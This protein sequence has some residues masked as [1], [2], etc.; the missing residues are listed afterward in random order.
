MM[1]RGSW[2]LLLATAGLSV[3]AAPAWAAPQFDFHFGL[4]STAPGTPSGLSLRLAARGEGKPP[5]LRSA[6]Y[7]A[8]AGIRF[9]TGAATECRA[10]DEEL[11]ALGARACPPKSRLTIGSFEAMTG[12]GPPI[13]PLHGDAHVFNGPG[14][15]IE[16]LTIPSTSIAPAFDR[17]TISGSTLTAHP[18]FAPGGPPEG[19]TSP[20]SLEFA[21]GPRVSGGRS[22]ITTPPA[23]P[24]SGLWTTRVR[25][26]F[27]DGT[28][29]TAVS[30]TPCDRGGGTA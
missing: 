9:D 30:T 7:A 16:V 23:C 27:G 3:A 10:S 29:A 17:V 13:D 20:R 22:L 18:P 12:F 26:G 19:E 2:P 25:L 6:V 4:T 24:E 15:L 8:P 5:P 14:Q 21:F 11:H 1:R 28:T